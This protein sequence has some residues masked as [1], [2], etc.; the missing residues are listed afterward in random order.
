MSH[1][2]TDTHMFRVNIC[3]H[4]VKLGCMTDTRQWCSTEIGSVAEASV[5]G[6]FGEGIVEQ[7]KRHGDWKRNLGHDGSNLIRE[8]VFLKER[9]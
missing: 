9:E 5:P 8:Q 1:N 4:L 6:R 3:T 7:H 2:I